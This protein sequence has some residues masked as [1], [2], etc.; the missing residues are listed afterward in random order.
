M[1]TETQRIFSRKGN[2]IAEATIVDGVPHGFIRFWHDNGQLARETP[3]NRGLEDGLCR[4]WDCNGKLLGTYEMRNGNG[5][6]REWHENGTLASEIPCVDGLRHGAATSWDETGLPE[7]NSIYY[8]NGRVV[9]KAKFDRLSKERDAIK[10]SEHPPPLTGETL[11]NARAARAKAPDILNKKST[12]EEFARELSLNGVEALSWLL[13]GEPDTRTLGEDWTLGDSIRFVERVYALGALSVIAFDID[14][15]DAVFQNTGHLA[16]VLP[17]PGP[18][19]AALFDLEREFAEKRGYQG[20]RDSGG[21]WLR[22]YL[23]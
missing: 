14:T 21:K 16:I 7:C 15:Y 19:R 12:G 23:K 11:R 6:S 10:R 18:E 22:L 2:L 1:N 13:E 20:T 9:S 17:Q 3:M 5:I 4:Q 8:F